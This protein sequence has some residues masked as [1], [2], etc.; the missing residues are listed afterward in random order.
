MI[1]CPKP[2]R[3][4]KPRKKRP[5]SERKTLDAECRELLKE[6]VRLRDGGCVTPG[7]WCYGYLTH[8]HYHTAL[9]SRLR[10][11]LR[12]NNCQCQGCNKRHNT[13]IEHYEA[14]M[15]DHYGLDVVRELDELAKI[16]HWKWTLPELRE[17]R[18]GLQTEYSAWKENK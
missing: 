13:Y 8:S 1:P 9:K 10:Y 17:I 5:K 14:Y 4:D 16:E 15:L 18:D 2:T 11:D 7:N 6:I 12:N 3:A